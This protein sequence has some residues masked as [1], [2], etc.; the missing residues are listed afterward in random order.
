L[1]QH[2]GVGI[3][4]TFI[5]I[6]STSKRSIAYMLRQFKVKLLMSFTI[7]DQ[8]VV[9]ITDGAPN[10][11][12]MKDVR[13]AANNL[14]SSNPNIKI[15]TIGLSTKDVYGGSQMLYDIADYVGGVKQF[16]EAEKASD[17]EY[18]LLY[19]LNSIIA[20][21]LVRGTITDT[22]DSAFYPVDENGNPISAGVYNA[23]G[24]ID[25]A[26]Y[27]DYVSNGKPTTAHANETFYTWEQIG[28]KWRITWYNQEI[29]WNDDDS[30]TGNPWTGNSTYSFN[31]Q[32]GCIFRA[33]TYQANAR[34]SKSSA[35]R[36]Q[37]RNCPTE[38]S[39]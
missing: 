39:G 10:G 33:F 31:K 14:R 28:D 24:K 16:Y 20:K 6:C 25:N 3:V 30:S 21:G 13:T 19:I 22:I 2:F 36:M 26:Q 38:K 34:C 12:S 29:G 4:L 15:I 1:Q 37:V 9:L 5:H 18:I 8:Y 27:S 7:T 35:S 11:P 23:S 32:S 17:L